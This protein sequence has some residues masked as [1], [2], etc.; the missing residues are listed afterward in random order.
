[1]LASMLKITTKPSNIAMFEIANQITNAPFPWNQ[2]VKTKKIVPC[3][4]GHNT[5]AAFGL[6]NGMKWNHKKHILFECFKIGY[7]GTNPIPPSNTSF[8]LPL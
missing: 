5:K 2:R 6:T 4:F 8:F 3:N 7:N 1:M